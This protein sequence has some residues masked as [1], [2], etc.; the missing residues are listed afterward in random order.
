MKLLY[1]VPNV[2]NEGGVARVLAIKTYYLIEKW[3][4]HIDFLTQ[5]KGSFPH[6][7]NFNKKIGFHDMLLQGNP[8][9]FILDYKRKLN[10]QIE[11][12]NPDIIVVCDNGFKAFLLPFILKTKIP[13]VLEI[14]SSLSVVEKENDSIFKL[15]GTQLSILFKK[16][17]ARKFDNFVVE[18][19]ESIKEWNVPNGIVIP[20]PL[21]F[22][23]DK[24]AKLNSKK[25]IAVGRHVYEKGF[26][27]LLHIWK[28]I[29]KKHPDWHLDI[30]GKSS[31]NLFLQRLT[32][33]LNLTNSVSFFAPTI[34]IVSKYQE[35]SI[36][37]MTSRF[38]GFGMVL[39]EAMASGLPCIAY[40]CPCGPKAIIENKVNGFL[41]ENGSESDFV[42]ATLLLINNE[43]K[44]IEMGKNAKQKSL[45]YHIDTIMPL[46]DSLFKEIKSKSSS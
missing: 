42:D 31:D 8:I 41:I 2:N 27:R 17:V 4:Y 35:N 9:Q 7:Y 38:E 12:L 24:S 1:L 18:T 13:V 34:D 5:N 20:N 10:E 3:N 15:I 14:H 6:F 21:W 33:K 11:L 37:L 29:V 22:N 44:R 43:S 39:I 45:N 28:Q 26:D 23:S 30:Y 25:V 36:Y 32:S 40:D 46:W 19:P 16:L